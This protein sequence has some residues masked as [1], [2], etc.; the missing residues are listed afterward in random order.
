MAEL[1]GGVEVVVDLTVEID[2]PWKPTCVAQAVHRFC[3]WSHDELAGHPPKPARAR[4][5]PHRCSPS[6]VPPRTA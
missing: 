6:A 3:P 2:G 5:P 1:N 4:S